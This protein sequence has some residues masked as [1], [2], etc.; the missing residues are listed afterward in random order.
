VENLI[1]LGYSGA[2]YPVNPKYDRVLGFQCYP[3]VGAIPELVDA[4]M[5]A[6]GPDR[7]VELV[8]DCAANGVAATVITADGFAE[9][10]PEGEA[11]QARLVDIARQSNMAVC[12]PNCMGVVN[13]A[14]GGA[15]YTGVLERP[16]VRGNISAVLQSGSLGIALMNNQRGVAF[17]YLI[18]SGNEAVVSAAEYVHFL[19]ED[20]GTRI[21]ALALEGIRDP[22][23]LIAAVD[24]AHLRGKAVVL[25]KLGTTS[26]GQRMVGAHTGALAGAV[27]VTR[28][29]CRQFGILFVTDLEEL[30]TTCQLFARQPSASGAR[31]GAITLSGGYATLLADLGEAAGLTFPSW[32]PLTRERLTSVIAGST[33]RNPFDAWGNGD[34]RIAV[35]Q[36]LLAIAADPSV[37]TVVVM[38]DLPPDGAANGTDVPAGVVEI[39]CDF[40]PTSTKPVVLVGTLAEAPPADWRTR[41]MQ[42]GVVYLGGAATGA[43]ALAHWSLH[44]A[45]VRGQRLLPPVDSR[46]PP[47]SIARWDAR[48]WQAAGIDVAG[49][50]LTRSVAEARVAADELGWPIVLK[51][52]SR[53]MQ[54]KSDLGG[55][56]L[57]VGPADLDD[58]YAE[59]V[60]RISSKAP[61]IRLDGILV[62]RQAPAG[63]E[64]IVGA[65]RDADWKWVVMLGLGGIFVESLRDVT[66]RRPPVHLPDAYAMFAELRG[67]ALLKGTRGQR[68]RDVDALARLVVSVSQLIVDHGERLRQLEFNPVLVYPKGEGLKVVDRLVVEKQ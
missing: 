28:A 21:I 8:Q 41:L 42:A 16:L 44:R 50:Q 57:D 24:A 39:V 5:I 37:D 14:T 33:A 19:A 13:N 30:L 64:M 3:E 68:P 12:G 53:D 48:S 62:Q 55:V 45:T 58:A 52:S 43:R 4:A 35:S 63:L 22:D 26:A 10:G 17:R 29:L 61:E 54:H 23:R 49:E 66:F 67:Q 25:L 40:A 9:S 7:A 2:I 36:S 56:V 60:A 47:A 15:L 51:V 20:E 27:E 46:T 65:T 32:S 38:Q 18:S 31:I 1:L 59:L 6:T 11:R 34:F